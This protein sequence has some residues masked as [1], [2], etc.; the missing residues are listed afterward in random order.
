[1]NVELEK[2]VEVVMASLKGLSQHLPGETKDNHRNPL[3]R[4]S[5]LWAKIRSGTSRI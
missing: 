3:V 5:C 4:I 2:D 1:V